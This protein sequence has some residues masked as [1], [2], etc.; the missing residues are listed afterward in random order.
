MSTKKQ[1]QSGQGDVRT[2]N[3]IARIAGV[4]KKSVSRAINDEPGISPATRARLKSIMEEHGYAPDRRAR[5]LAS[6]KSFLIGMAYNN[7]NPGYVMEMLKGVQAVA[8][9]AGYEVV[10]H[11]TKASGAELSGELVRFFQRSG[12]DA[13]ILTPPLSESAEL[14]AALSK[15]GK[16]VVRI[17]GDDANFSI[18]QV[19]YD[20]RS[21]AQAVTDRMISLGHRRIGFLGGAESSGTTR[22][23]LAGYRDALRLQGLRFDPALI[24]FADFTFASGASEG[25]ALLCSEDRPSAIVCANDEMASGVLHAARLHELKVPKDLAVSGFDDSLLARQVWP[26]LTSVRQPIQEMAERAAQL[27]LGIRA[28]EVSGLPDEFSHT[29]IERESS[30]ETP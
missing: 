2:I 13:L 22:R 12:C 3:D 19:R 4:S 7:P 30:G 5:A 17:A 21:A 11:A 10:M 28:P 26:P 20:D 14:L 8:E 9:P 16:T 15:T 27:A 1:A 24:R 6:S 18:I 29:L 23:R 25:D